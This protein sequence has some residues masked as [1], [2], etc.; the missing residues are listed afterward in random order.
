MM[1]PKKNGR[2]HQVKKKKEAAENITTSKNEHPVFG[3][4]WTI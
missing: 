2:E 1:Q 3:E 4:K